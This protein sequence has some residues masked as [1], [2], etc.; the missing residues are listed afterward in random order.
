[1]YRWVQTVGCCAKPGSSSR[2]STPNGGCI[3]CASSHRWNSTRGSSRFAG[4]G[5]STS[6]RSSVTSIGGKMHARRPVDGKDASDEEA[7][8]PELRAAGARATLVFV[9]HLNHRPATAWLALTGRAQLRESGGGMAYLSRPRRARARRSA[10]RSHPGGRRETVGLGTAE[11]GVCGATGH[12]AHRV[13]GRR[14]P[15]GRGQRRR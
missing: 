6:A 8:G 4:F 3:A 5:P 7:R 9:R 12:R 1:M 10:A 15:G 14:R 2:V 11:R 13:A